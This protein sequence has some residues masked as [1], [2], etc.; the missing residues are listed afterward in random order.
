MSAEAVGR[1]VADLRAG[2]VFQPVMSGQEHNNA[3]LF[4]HATERAMDLGPVVDV[5]PIWEGMSES[6]KPITLYEAFPCIIPPWKSALFALQ[7]DTGNVF[8]W[9][10]T[11]TDLAN[12]ETV[13]ITIASPDHTDF[14]GGLWYTENDVDWGRVRWVL[15]S[16]L[17]VGGRGKT[18]PKQTAGPL[19]MLQTAIYND[20]A[21]ADFHWH[22]IVA[23]VGHEEMMQFNT[24]VV[25]GLNFLNSRNV[26]AVEPVR[27]NA[28]RKRIARTGVVVTQIHVFPSGRSTTSAAQGQLIGPSG[29]AS[30]RGHFAEY[31]DQ[32]GKGKLFGKY[33]GRF[34]IPQHA[35]GSKGVGESEQEFILHPEAT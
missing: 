34:Y 15:T 25:A 7:N 18:G 27:D 1:V 8:V 20:G 12:G 31:G 32:Y 21:P 33:E 28:T 2:R 5:T 9:T 6:A 19:F 22:Q 4:H 29:H 35:R 23:T 30:V 11:T 14:D 16:W 10:M 3:K 13:P 24:A 17:F 26:S